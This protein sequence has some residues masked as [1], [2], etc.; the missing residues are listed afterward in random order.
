MYDEYEDESEEDLYKEIYGPP[1]F[2]SYGDGDGDVPL[3]GYGEVLKVQ[4]DETNV[5]CNNRIVKAEEHVAVKSVIY[6]QQ[7][8]ALIDLYD[9]EIEQV[10]VYR[11]KDESLI[12]IAQSMIRKH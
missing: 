11:V 12:L 4:I 10:T 7:S 8:V 1:I 3:K 6:F 9:D 5:Y 2:D